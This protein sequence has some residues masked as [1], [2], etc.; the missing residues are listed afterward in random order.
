QTLDRDH[1]A[2]L[3]VSFDDRKLV[4]F[5]KDDKHVEEWTVDR[6][7][8]FHIG[9]DLLIVPQL[10]NICIQHAREI[11]GDFDDCHIDRFH[12]E[13]E[14]KQERL[15]YYPVFVITYAH[16]PH[17]DYRCLVDGCTG[18][19]IGE[20]QYSLIKVTLAALLASYPLSLVGLISLGFIVH[21]S[22]GAVLPKLLST[23]FFFVVALCFASLVGLYARDIPRLDRLRISQQQWQNYRSTASQ[24]TYDFTRPFQEQY[25]SF[26]QQRSSRPPPL[27]EDR[28][29][30][31]LYDLLWV[32]RTAS[33][34]E[35]KRA[36]LTK[37]KQLHPDRNPGNRQA[38][39]QFKRVNQAYA[40]LSDKFK[41]KQYDRYGYESVK[42]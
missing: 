12:L 10:K 4:S 20:R 41:R 42:Y 39:E 6:E 31:D 5:N 27:P 8:A 37:A 40:I 3:D 13:I 2:Q 17:S 18:R 25:Q 7:T 22:V 15:L 24:F 11:Y 1:L 19:A 29:S 35:I 26:R 30:I 14:S 16:G 38:E 21:P 28:A 36:Y 33:E 34:Q 9:W 23:P 32:T